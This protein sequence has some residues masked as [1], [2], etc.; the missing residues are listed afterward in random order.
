MI[1]GVK[2]GIEV[3]I[4]KAGREI[5]Q[6]KIDIGIEVLKKARSGIDIETGTPGT[7]IETEVR[8]VVTEVPETVKE[9]HMKRKITKKEEETTMG[10]RSEAK[11]LKEIRR[12]GIV[13]MEG[14]RVMRRS[15]IHKEGGSVVRRSC[16]HKLTESSHLRSL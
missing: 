7:V 10:K 16:I 14:G 11:A 9:D 3:G 13:T 15:C 6:E 4:T 2:S 1:I 8:E 12:G 5:D